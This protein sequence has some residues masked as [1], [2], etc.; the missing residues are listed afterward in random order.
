MF[1]IS[2]FPLIFSVFLQ[3]LFVFAYLTLYAVA[4]TLKPPYIIARGLVFLYLFLVCAVVLA[5]GFTPCFANRK[6]LSF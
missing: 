5:F 4:F 3:F 2:Y 6:L 1:I